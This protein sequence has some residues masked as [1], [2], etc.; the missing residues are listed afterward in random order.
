[1]SSFIDI[2]TQLYLFIIDQLLDFTN[3]FASV[4]PHLYSRSVTLK[5]FHFY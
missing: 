2:H 5:Y 1:M 3:S 4:L